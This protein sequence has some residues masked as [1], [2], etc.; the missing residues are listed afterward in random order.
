MM[1]NGLKSGDIVGMMVGL[2]FAVSA[3]LF[4]MGTLF[5][6][7]VHSKLRAKGG[8]ATKASV[9]SQSVW[10]LAQ[11]YAGKIFQLVG[12]INLPVFLLLSFVLY[13]ITEYIWFFVV[14]FGQM[15]PVMFCFL[16][17][18][19][20]LS[21]A[22]G[23]GALK[24]SPRPGH[25]H[26]MPVLSLIA[27]ICF[28]VYAIMQKD[29]LGIVCWIFV[30]ILGSLLCGLSAHKKIQVQYVLLGEMQMFYVGFTGF[31]YVVNRDVYRNW[32]SIV[33]LGFM[34]FTVV[35]DRLFDFE[36]GIR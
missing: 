33:L 10:E 25:Y 8:Y 15:V 34:I 16:L 12:L 13:H 14:C 32:G 20:K 2:I 31:L 19:M 17:I 30:F 29:G 21:R 11:G 35:C 4:G 36:G 18:E 23:E 5:K 6:A 27:G 9:K 7:R 3:M 28:V 26:V 24:V 1:V 22:G